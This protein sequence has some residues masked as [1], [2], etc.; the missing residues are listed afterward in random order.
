MRRRNTSKN[1]FARLRSRS[2]I[3]TWQSE[4]ESAFLPCG[5][6]LF[7]EQ[8]GPPRTEGVP[9]A[10]R[11]EGESSPGGIRCL[12]REKRRVEG[13]GNWSSDENRLH[14][15]VGG[16]RIRNP[17]AST[18]LKME[19]SEM[20]VLRRPLT[21]RIKVISLII[22]IVAAVVSI[23]TYLSVRRSEELLEQDVKAS[24]IM[25]A[26]AFAE[27][28]RNRKELQDARSLEREI[29]DIMEVRPLVRR[30]D[31]FTLGPNGLTLSASS[32]AGGDVLKIL[33]SVPQEVMARLAREG[34]NRVW[35]VVT[36][37][38]FGNDV[39][40]ALRLRVSLQR[41]DELAARTRLQ[42]FLVMT[43]AVVLIVGVLGI[44]FHRTVDRPIRELIQTMDRAEAGD[45]SARVE[46]GPRDEIGQ[47]GQSLN[48]MLGR[49]EESYHQNLALLHQ[50]NRFNEE[51][52]EKVRL[53]TMELERRNEELTR[54]NE[55]LFSTQIQLSRSERLATVGELAATVAHEIATPL[56]SISGHV[57]LLLQVPELNSS[58]GN[59]LKIVEDQIARTVEI[60]QGI[61]NLVRQPEPV[62]KTIDVNGLLKE[63][64][65]LT[66]PG[67]GLK[68]VFVK[69]RFGH[70]LSPVLGD[71]HQLQQVFLN[72]IANAMDAMPDGGILTVETGPVD[73]LSERD[74]SRWV[75]IQFTDTGRGIAPEDQRRIFD[76]FFTTKE[77]GEGTGLG[78]TVCQGII[79]AHQGTVEM[80][81]RVG[82]GT[83]FA[84]FLP[85][86]E[87]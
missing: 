1:R 22:L 15:R 38:R 83:T 60:L 80:E 58:V 36:P 49:I 29:G 27:G 78:L 66:S 2:N 24:G 4:S 12:D 18:G 44:F 23:S 26:T 13:D 81:S 28:I 56:N 35:E 19:R 32:S 17:K 14:L 62:L 77:R 69:A 11:H 31:V 51:L 76:P 59:R 87:T 57:Q 42:F 67:L 10:V 63:I 40:G 6:A 33:D 39:A 25:L 20:A 34:G 74:A 7:L 50:I 70:D 73:S 79:R 47:L 45:L 21:L 16:A 54:A 75:R 37:I 61:L 65:D 68:K 41:A 53:A 84:I 55:L 5:E 48:H 82:S 85:A 46:T 86:S 30:I 52:K 64:L 72:L 43:V 3:R 9:E 71:V 8:D